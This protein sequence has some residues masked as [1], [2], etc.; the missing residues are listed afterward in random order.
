[1]HVVVYENSVGLSSL[2]IPIIL[3]SIRGIPSIVCSGTS[4]LENP[5]QQADTYVPGLENWGW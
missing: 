1:M 5:V 3:Y 2:P 4:N